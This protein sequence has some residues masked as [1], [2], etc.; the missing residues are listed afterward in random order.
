MMSHPWLPY[1]LTLA[2]A[3]S[4]G[5]KSEG[6][7][8]GTM[9]DDTQ[10]PAQTYP[11]EQETYTPQT[12]SPEVTEPE[13]T[14]PET[15]EPKTQPAPPPK[16]ERVVFTWESK[17]EGHSGEMKTTLPDD[18]E[19]FTGEFHQITET[20]S[21]AVVDVFYDT[22]YADP[23]VGPGWMWDGGWGQYEPSEFIRYYSGHVVALLTGDKGNRMRC[24]FQ[25]D[26]PTRGMN[27]G[28]QGEC[29]LSNGDRITSVFAAA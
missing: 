12:T 10:Q 6:S 7:F 15:T 2:L 20:T 26:D 1:S 3:L 19:A 14:E 22:W 5:C 17:D 4:V 16:Y 11:Q 24:D 28:G 29:Q 23:W 25:L 27:G 13:T 9:R 8:S 18:G 21:V